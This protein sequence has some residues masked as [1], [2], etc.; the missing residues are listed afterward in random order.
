MMNNV[1]NKTRSIDCH[2]LKTKSKEIDM[3]C[4]IEAEAGTTG[5]C[6]GDSGHGCRTYL[7]IEN[8]A[9]TD[10]RPQLLYNKYGDLTGFEVKFGGDLE[11][12]AITEALR[13]MA[14]TLEDMEPKLKEKLN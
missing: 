4:I 14:D 2:K 8:I 1:K 13:F 7:K 10:I 6:G 11:L 12:Y 5:L 3:C 9:S